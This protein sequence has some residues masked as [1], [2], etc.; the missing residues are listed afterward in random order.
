MDR[1]EFREH[2]F[3][4]RDGLQLYARSYGDVRLGR[5]PVVCLP[6][7]TRNSRDF[8]ELAA[9]L[10]SPS[11]GG[12]FILS[13]DSRGRGGSQRDDDTTRYTIAAETSDLIAACA[14]L[15]IEKAIFIG[16]SRGGLILH[17]LIGLA[18]ALIARV[19]LND[20]GPVI[21]IEGLLRIRDY[22]NA[23]T[24]PA[25]WT[26]APRYLQSVHGDDFPV[27]R[28]ADWREMA[29]AIYRDEGGIPV[30][31]FDPAIA[32]Q[33]QALTADTSLPDLWPQFSAFAGLP[34]MVVR[35]EHSR[36]LSQATV[37]EMKRRHPN[38]IT[39]TAVGQGHAP[40][41]HLDD[42]RQAI[43]AFLQR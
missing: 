11:G 41:L 38:L 21:E 19:I 34:M 18:P 15:G 6:G 37:E 35:G 8:H 10:A 13:L 26:A 14:Y 39:V 43:A 4:V 25:S 27:L 22:L 40:L 7:L 33:L 3:R 23:A 42:P 12:H 2:R 24:G 16:T 32:A 31:D 30:G 36:L 28:E 17:H 1:S 29:K 5:I 9:Y 20:I